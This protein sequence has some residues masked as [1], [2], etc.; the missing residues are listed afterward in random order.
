[1][2]FE[3]IKLFKVPLPFFITYQWLSLA[4][5]VNPSSFICSCPFY[6]GH[7]FL[8]LSL[9]LNYLR[10]FPQAVLFWNQP[11]P[12]LL[13][14]LT[15]TQPS[16]LSLNVITSL[17]LPQ[18]SDIFCGLSTVHI[19]TAPFISSIRTLRSQNC[20]YLFNCLSPTLD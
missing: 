1:M 12:S 4:P 8:T 13:T 10:T 20:N 15:A 16:N 11:P 2:V 19:H 6:L 17:R 7:F 3:R 5:R 9:S 18:C 14:C